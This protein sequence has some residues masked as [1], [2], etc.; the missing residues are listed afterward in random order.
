MLQF[1]NLFITNPIIGLKPQFQIRLHKI[2]YCIE[3]DISFKQYQKF[4]QDRLS[5]NWPFNKP[6]ASND[7][8][9]FDENYKWWLAGFIEA[10]ACFSVRQ[11]GRQSF[12]VGQKYHRNLIESIKAF[13]G[14][15][16]KIMERKKQKESPYFVV[17]VANAVCCFRIR[18]FFEIYQ[19]LGQ[20]SVAFENFKNHINNKPGYR[21]YYTNYQTATKRTALKIKA[22]FNWSL[23]M[24]Y[25]K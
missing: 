8:I 23:V 5:W 9:K 25:L 11:N 6:V 19:L 4:E 21:K 12:S 10:E 7:P 13:Y 17:E 15:E 20:K 3:N 18:N 14:I 2:K 22:I 24:C 1:V 16:T